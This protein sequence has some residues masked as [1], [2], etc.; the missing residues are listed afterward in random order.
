MPLDNAFGL[1]KIEKDAR[2]APRFYSCCA[3][4]QGSAFLV[5]TLHGA[6][7][8]TCVPQPL[9]NLFLFILLLAHCQRINEKYE[10]VEKYIP[11][12]SKPLYIDGSM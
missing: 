1:H 2:A 10:Y 5:Y 7:V 12:L 9:V 3:R 6:L 8:A 4:R 11:R